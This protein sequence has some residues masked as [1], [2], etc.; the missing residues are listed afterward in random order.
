MGITQQFN[1]I[2]FSFTEAD[3]RSDEVV[4]FVNS[5]FTR[6][7]DSWDCDSNIRTLSAPMIDS[8]EPSVALPQQSPLL[9]QEIF[10]FEEAISQSQSDFFASLSHAP[11]DFFLSCSWQGHDVCDIDIVSTITEMGQCWDIQ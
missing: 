11:E 5:S 4:S 2:V 8:A 3:L 9:D 7:C 10:A 1:D 6:A